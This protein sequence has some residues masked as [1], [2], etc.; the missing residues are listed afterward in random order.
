M[1]PL[2]RPII[3]FC[4]YSG[5]GKTTLLRRLIPLLDGQGLR[6]GLVKHAHHEFEVDYPGKDSFELRKAG[7]SQ[8]VVASR[9][10]MACISEFRESKSE[11]TL[12]EALIPLCPDQ[13]DL[14]LVEGF[15]RETIPKIELHRSALGSPLIC[16]NDSHVV[17]VATDDPGLDTGVPGMTLLDLNRPV[18][19]S[20]FLLDYLGFKRWKQARQGIG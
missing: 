6:V 15:K 8:V 12:Q 11:P 2:D 19:I 18:Q 3:G 13:L 10:R 16:S 14:V 1:N 7:A 9:N 4:A 5:N 20:D 17:A